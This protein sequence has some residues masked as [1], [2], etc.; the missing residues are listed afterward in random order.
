MI[1]IKLKKEEFGKMRIE[2][3]FK[4]Y[5]ISNETN[6]LIIGTFNPNISKNEATFFYGRKR[7]FLWSLLPKVFDE[8][9]LKDKSTKLKLDFMHTYKID[10]IDLISEVEIEKGRENDYSDEYLDN[11]ILRWNNIIEII[12]DNPI[13]EVYFTRKTFSNIK[14]I[15]N[16]ISNIEKY[17]NENKIKF[18]CLDTPARYENDKK[19][20]IGKMLLEDDDENKRPANLFQTK[21][22][23]WSST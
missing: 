19:L 13:K 8:E 15:K 3:K 20:K 4:D 2:H 11:K 10:F 21:R 14:N 1:D 5:K 6:I 16:K 9:S 23:I 17:C 7:N 12:K 22:K 18:Y